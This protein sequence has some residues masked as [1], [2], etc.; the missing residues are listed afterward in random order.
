MYKEDIWEI[1]RVKAEK[2]GYKHLMAWFAAFTDVALSEPETFE[3][4]LVWIAAKIVA[5]Q[6]THQ[7]FK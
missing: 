7:K 2:S 3:G 4:Y 1:V 5:C 6:L